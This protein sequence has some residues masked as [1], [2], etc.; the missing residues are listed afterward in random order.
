MTTICAHSNCNC[1]ARQGDTLCGHHA[2]RCSVHGCRKA[3]KPGHSECHLHE[4][5]ETCEICYEEIPQSDMR[6][7]ELCSHSFCEKCIKKWLGSGLENS[8]KCPM[9]RTYIVRDKTDLMNLI[10]Y[11]CQRTQT[12]RAT[13]PSR[14]AIADDIFTVLASD[15]ARKNIPE[16]F[17]AIVKMKLLQ[18]EEIIYTE[19]RAYMEKWKKL[20][21]F[22]Y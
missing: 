18:F 22:V 4:P 10:K 12:P 19:D 14:V 7:L 9:C 2:P 21:H 3:V 6:H 8:R 13:Y 5:R 16:C 1:R 17:W 15:F 20:M 11:L